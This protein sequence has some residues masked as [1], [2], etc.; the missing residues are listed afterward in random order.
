M[1]RNRVGH[2]WFLHAQ[3]VPRDGLRERRDLE[4][5]ADGPRP[6]LPS[7]GLELHT[8][9]GRPPPPPPPAVI[10]VP[11]FVQS[12]SAAPVSPSSSSFGG[13][14]GLF[15]IIDEGHGERLAGY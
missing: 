11:T 14:G 7:R 8:G 13:N 1:P 9:G 3:S 15:P 10:A 2:L 5:D 12:V 6:C 4:P